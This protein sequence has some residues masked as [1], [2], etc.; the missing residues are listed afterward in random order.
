M[1][2]AVSTA[3]VV[4]TLGTMFTLIVLIALVAYVIERF[5]KNAPQRRKR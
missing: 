5:K 4:L 3:F 2:L 1:L